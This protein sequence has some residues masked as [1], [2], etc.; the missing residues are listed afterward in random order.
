MHIALLSAQQH[1][2]LTDLLVELYAYYNGESGTIARDVV[3][4]HL[5]ENLLSPGSPLRL[6]V[7]SHPERG[8]VGFAA[9]AVLY[10][11][12]D[13]TPPNRK[14]CLLKEL[15]VRSAERGHGVGQRLMLWVGE[16]AVAQGCCRIDWNVKASNHR[17][18]AF[19]ESLGAEQ[20]E[21]RLSLR[22]TGAKIAQLPRPSE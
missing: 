11:L 2:T 22:V 17:G 10:S 5:H 12:V 15:Y 13:P 14:Q 9:V 1:S 6:V 7:A 18:I 21:D 20:V 4:E 8:V 16:Y 3:E 19:Y